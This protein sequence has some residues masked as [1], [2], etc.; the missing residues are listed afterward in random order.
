MPEQKELERQDSLENIFSVLQNFAQKKQSSPEKSPI[1][2]SNRASSKQL[3]KQSTQDNV[4]S[5][6]SSSSSNESSSPSLLTPSLPNVT[7][8]SLVGQFSLAGLIA[9]VSKETYSSPT[10]ESPS[11]SLTPR[12]SASENLASASSI[13]SSVSTK[14]SQSQ[15]QHSIDFL[16]KSTVPKETPKSSNSAPGYFSLQSTNSQYQ[17][18]IFDSIESNS[19]LTSQYQSQE[20]EKSVETTSSDKQEKNK[21]TLSIQQL[22]SEA[23]DISIPNEKTTADQNS[24]KIS[25][26]TPSEMETDKSTSNDMQRE[27]VLDTLAMLEDLEKSNVLSEMC[28]LS[29]EAAVSNKLPLLDGASEPL[30]CLESTYNNIDG[31]LRTP[32]KASEEENE[33]V[34][35]HQSFVNEP[36]ELSTQLTTSTL[37]PNGF[38]LESLPSEI[39]AHSDPE[40]SDKVDEESIATSVTLPLVSQSLESILVP[41]VPVKL[42]SKSNELSDKVASDSQL[43]QSNMLNNQLDLQGENLPIESDSTKHV[44]IVPLSD[45]QSSLKNSDN[46]KPSEDTLSAQ[47]TTIQ[48]LAAEPI[49]QLGDDNFLSRTGRPIEPSHV[50]QDIIPHETGSESSQPTENFD[51]Q[52]LSQNVIDKTLGLNEEKLE[53]NRNESSKLSTGEALNQTAENALLD[54]AAGDNQ[55]LKDFDNFETFA[56]IQNLLADEDLSSDFVA[57]TLG[58]TDVINKSVDISVSAQLLNENELTDLPDVYLQTETKSTDRTN[59]C[60]PTAVEAKSSETSDIIESDTNDQAKVSNASVIEKITESSQQDAPLGSRTESAIAQNTLESFNTEKESSAEITLHLGINS[61]LQDD[62]PNKL[63]NSF[64]VGEALSEIK[65]Q[66]F[67]NTETLADSGLESAEI[68]SAHEIEPSQSLSNQTSVFSENLSMEFSQQLPSESSNQIDKSE[69]TSISEPGKLEENSFVPPVLTDSSQLF[70]EMLNEA[71]NSVQSSNFD[72][73][74]RGTK[75]KSID[76]M[77]DQTPSKKLRVDE[78]IQ[79]EELV[80]EN[81]TVS[82]PTIEMENEISSNITASKNLD[83]EPNKDDNETLAETDILNTIEK[84]L[85]G[86][87]LDLNQDT[88]SV[89]KDFPIQD[90]SMNSFLGQMKSSEDIFQVDNDV[91]FNLGSDIERNAEVSL[92]D[93]I[94]LEGQDNEDSIRTTLNLPEGDTNVLN[95][96]GNE[97]VAKYDDIQQKVNN[98]LVEDIE[99]NHTTL[100]CSDEDKVEDKTSSPTTIES[101]NE[102]NITSF[103]LGGPNIIQS[104]IMTATQEVETLE[105]DDTIE[106]ND[107]NPSS[108]IADVIVQEQELEKVNIDSFTVHHQEDTDLIPIIKEQE[109]KIG[110]RE[111]K[112][113]VINE[114][115]E[116]LN[117][118]KEE[119]E[120]VQNDAENNLVVEQPLENIETATKTEVL[121]T[122]NEDNEKIGESTTLEHLETTNKIDHAEESLNSPVISREPSS[123]DV[124]TAVFKFMPDEEVIDH[125]QVN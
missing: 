28:K 97:V 30:N 1:Q 75:R 56:A 74:Q 41:S 89:P 102:E 70:V 100:E 5:L 19:L 87:D 26:A 24:S 106:M 80:F 15:L 78:P 118:E 16:Q 9:P 63:V 62:N 48:S 110:V 12:S 117:T 33:I 52:D 49:P 10:A 69:V 17:G 36:T 29:E 20:K 66:T 32:E 43:E 37:Q 64:P 81:N 45:N 34:S 83:N 98:V 14:T 57:E 35:Q 18:S 55:V 42:V 2:S 61:N 22:L 73:E 119:N 60:F 88:N 7:A 46:D 38:E 112:K 6:L 13:S 105:L 21:H 108:E 94:E 92:D 104:E 111:E 82:L 11:K 25:L 76:I 122:L 96:E 91:V 84:T 40:R 124:V 23:T 121:H 67:S 103:Q 72:T 115:D 95:F 86:K 65:S 8:A 47:E 93:T 125:I 120:N 123:V 107:E 90:E 51:R 31:D 79:T 109:V 54:M 44:D 99:S 68:S 71:D 50:M 116:K 4:S 114:D 101:L 39:F 58:D 59:E 85:S 3:S 27:E 77:E 53:S 113:D